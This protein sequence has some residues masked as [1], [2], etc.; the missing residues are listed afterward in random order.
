MPSSSAIA[1]C[2]IPYTS[3]NTTTLR[4]FA[5]SSS[6]AVCDAVE[7]LGR[8]RALRDHLLGA[9]VDGLEV[10]VERDRALAAPALQV[11]RGGVR[12]DPVEPRGEGRVAAEL[13][14]A[15]PGPEVCLLHHVAR[16]LLVAGEAPRE[17][18][19]VDESAPHQ[20]VERLSVATTGGADQLGLVQPDLPDG[21]RYDPGACGKVTRRPHPGSGTH[22]AAAGGRGC[23]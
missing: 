13:P 10:V 7:R 1:S 2:D 15:L 16:V 20:L 21:Y 8:L 18:E 3:F 22:P 9:G 4:S 14:D 11:A 12:G 23:G 6:S 19:R 17:R 5:G